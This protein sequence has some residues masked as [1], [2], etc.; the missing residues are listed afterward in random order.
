MK[1]LI[2][3]LA[4]ILMVF[5]AQAQ[6]GKKAVRKA[7]SALGAFNLDQTNNRAKLQEAIDEIEV[8]VND[9]E[10]A[11]DAKTHLTKGEIYNEIANQYLIAAQLNQSTE[12]L[13]KVDNAAEMAAG[14]YIKAYELAEKKWEIR[15]ACKGM[16]QA[17]G[18]LSNA[19]VAAFQET[20]DFA[21]AYKDFKM[22]LDLDEILKKEGEASSLPSDEEY[23]N[24]LYIT[25]LAALNANEMDAAKMYFQKLYDMK[26][27]KPAIYESLYKINA[28]DDEASME[29]AYKYLEEG[30]KLF[31]DEVSIL[32]AEI[33]HFLRLGKLDALIDK[34]KAAID[35]EP[36]NTSLYSTLGNVYDNLY[37]KEQQAGNEAKAEEYFSNSLDYYQQAID[38]DPKYSDAIYSIGA[39]YYNKAALMTQE[40]NKYADDYSKEGLKKYEEIKEK[41]FAEFDKAL[42]YFQRAEALNPSDLNTLIALKEIYARKDDLEK[43]N[44]FKERIDK[45]QAGETIEDAYF[46]N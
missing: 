45:V 22:V 9:P 1:K 5:A 6:D 16:L 40:L 13:P 32:F 42:P 46:D 25:G 39:L 38:K 43:S 11:K 30:R 44:E 14:A 15:D 31:P 29:E 28:G 27:D 23:N 17:Q 10:T 21:K 36:E 12:G 41:V 7:S 20:G 3:A 26:Y 33:N 4:A 8:A 18:H 34:L 24:Q 19:G 37:Q 2:F 35:K